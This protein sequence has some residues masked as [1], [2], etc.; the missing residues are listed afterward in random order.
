LKKY[1]T[2]ALHTVQLR[3]EE[4]IATVPVCDGACSHDVVVGG[5]VLYHAHGS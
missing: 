4:R 5:K 2:P 1:V 3:V